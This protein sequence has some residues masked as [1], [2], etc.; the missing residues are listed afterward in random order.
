M[1]KKCRSAVQSHARFLI[2]SLAALALAGV[3]VITSGTTPAPLPAPD[4]AGIFDADG[5]V[6]NL[7]GGIDAFSINDKISNGVGL[8]MSTFP[9]RSNRMLVDNG[10]VAR[11]HDLGNGYAWVTRNAAGDLIVYAGV[12]RLSGT[13]DTYVEFEL[14]QGVMQVHTGPPWPIHGSRQENDLLVR[15]NFKAGVIDSA[16]FE[17]WN[18]T[19]YQRLFTAGPDG[20]N[21]SSY[22]YC[23]GAPPIVSTQDEVWDASGTPVQVPQPD[24]FVEIGIDVNSLLGSSVEFTSLQAKTPQDVILDSFRHIGHWA[25]PSQGGSR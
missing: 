24:S 23:A 7:E 2:L 10:T 18:G 1:L 16:D 8:D 12:E 19:S 5:K 14:N 25:N 15:V 3:A 9:D 6:I 22:R 13:A 20:C 11:E 21:G 17:R 4:W